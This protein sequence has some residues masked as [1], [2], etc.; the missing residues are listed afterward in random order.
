[1]NT[2]RLFRI[3]ALLFALFIVLV[4]LSAN[5]GLVG[6]WFG[7]LYNFPNGD[8]AGHFL[9]MGSLA[10][11][12]NLGFPGAQVGSRAFRLSKPSLILAGLI[13]LEEFS[14]SFFPNRHAS[15]LDLS[16]RLAGIFSL[17]GFG[18]Y[19]RRRW[20]EKPSGAPALRPE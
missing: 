10:L 18:A 13:T 7:W 1:M 5:I 9:L 20:V 6:Q 3:M 4:I 2:A 8:K 12:F 19:L 11:L 14:Q 16:A 15:L 17:G